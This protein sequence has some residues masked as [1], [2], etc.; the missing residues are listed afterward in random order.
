[1]SQPMPPRSPLSIVFILHCMVEMPLAIQGIWNPASLPF[2]QLTNTTLV[3]MKLYSLLL[4][5][6]CATSFLCYGLPDFLPGKRALAIGLCIYH[7]ACSTVLYQAPRII[8]HSFGTL[9]EGYNIIPE[10]VWGTVHGILGL[11]MVLWWQFT[12]SQTPSLA[13]G[14]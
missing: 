12:L 1:M 8:P 2:L 3:L 14:K 9:A 4:L 6:S 5:G 10:T 13:T 7:S 11:S